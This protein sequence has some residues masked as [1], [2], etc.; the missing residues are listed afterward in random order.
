MKTVCTKFKKAR[1]KYGQTI[2]VELTATIDS[3]TAA[4]TLIDVYRNR[5]K[6]LHRL[7]S[8]RKGQFAVDIDGRKSKYR[9]IFYVLNDEEKILYEI[10]DDI[11]SFY[12]KVKIVQ[13]EEVSDGHYGS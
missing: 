12:K 4:E 3:L 1:K 13:I 2:A 10:G 9:L 7:T 6:H 11:N 8:D 5:R